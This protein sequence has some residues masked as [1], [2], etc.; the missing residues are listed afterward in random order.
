MAMPLIQHAVSSEKPVDN[1][2]HL[3]E[4]WNLLA[5]LPRVIGEKDVLMYVH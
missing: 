3:E 2:L 5:F 1:I 4:P